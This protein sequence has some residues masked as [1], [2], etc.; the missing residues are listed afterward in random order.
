MEWHVASTESIVK[1]QE[2]HII[3]QQ[4][5]NYEQCVSISE[6][7]KDQITL[8]CTWK[9]MQADVLHIISM[10]RLKKEKERNMMPRHAGLLYDN[11]I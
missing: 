11:N 1:R 8:K 5:K 7:N 4:E 6:D 2:T 3:Q 10:S 9:F